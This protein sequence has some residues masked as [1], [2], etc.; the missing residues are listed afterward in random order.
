MKKG[1][2]FALLSQGK[3]VGRFEVQAVETGGDGP[4]CG[5]VGW[6][7]D[8][9]HAGERPRERYLA[10]AKGVEGEHRTF[11]REELPGRAAVKRVETW[12]LRAG[13]PEELRTPIQVTR[14]LRVETSAGPLDVLEA[15]G[16]TPDASGR[17]PTEGLLVAD[18]EGKSVVNVVVH[19]AQ[20]IKTTRMYFLDAL[21][22]GA[23]GS[24]E[25]LLLERHRDDRADFLVIQQTRG[26]GWQILYRTRPHLRRRYRSGPSGA[27]FSASPRDPQ[28][29]LPR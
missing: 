6:G 11:S 1:E 29:A 10:L 2:K 18:K 3:P 24:V 9:L 15:Q 20:A 27:A 19:P 14:A 4:G 5:G 21:D 7:L 23:D 22:V 8:E 28:P 25:L 16:G 17:F 26:E 13:V 12:W